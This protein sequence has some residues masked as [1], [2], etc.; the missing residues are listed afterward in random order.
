MSSDSCPCLFTA[1]HVAAKQN[2][3]VEGTNFH[4]LSVRREQFLHT[5]RHTAHTVGGNLAAYETVFYIQCR[6]LHSVLEQMSSSN[7]SYIVTY[8]AKSPEIGPTPSL[9]TK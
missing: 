1:F 2:S 9:I 8:V 5:R 7:A 6:P 3:T 4:L